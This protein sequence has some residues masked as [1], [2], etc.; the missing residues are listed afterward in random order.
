MFRKYV[1]FNDDDISP[2]IRKTIT[3]TLKD[4]KIRTHKLTLK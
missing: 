3:K 1:L 4:G 2:T